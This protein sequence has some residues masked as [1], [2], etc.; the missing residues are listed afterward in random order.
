VRVVSVFFNK[1]IIFLFMPYICVGKIDSGFFA[2]KGLIRF[3]V[4]EKPYDIT[5]I[6]NEYFLITP[7]SRRVR[8]KGFT[9]NT[10][11]VV[12]ISEEPLSDWAVCK[13]LNEL[14]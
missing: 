14:K 3:F 8:V 9:I 12:V 1:A 10:D 2:A 5:Q 7:D 11:L 4:N 13:D 6:D